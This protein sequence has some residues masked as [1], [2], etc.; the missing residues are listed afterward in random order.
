[1]KVSV[2]VGDLERDDDTVAARDME[3]AEVLN[4]IFFTSVFTIEDNENCRTWR[5]DTGETFYLSWS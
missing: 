4:Q 3:K 5:K 1:M 2:H